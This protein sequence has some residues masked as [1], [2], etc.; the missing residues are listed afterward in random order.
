[1]TA[2]PEGPLSGLATHQQHP[3]ATNP[4]LHHAVE[5]SGTSGRLMLC[6]ALAFQ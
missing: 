1:M 2:Q 5:S 6:D 3:S 4:Q